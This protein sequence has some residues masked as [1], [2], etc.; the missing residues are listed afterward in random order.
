M[1]VRQIMAI[2]KLLFLGHPLATRQLHQT[3]LPKVLALP[4][5]SSD[6]LSSIAYATQEI[7]LVLGAAGVAALSLLLP[8][9]LSV[10][11]LF[12]IVVLSYRQ[13]VHA[14]PTGGGAYRVAHENLGIY[15]GLLAAAALLVDYILT[16]SVSV[17]AGTDAIA[18]AIPAVQSFSL[19]LTLTFLL[20]VTLVNLRGARQSALLFAIPAYGF[21]AS[22][23]ALIL[24]GLISC[25]HVCPQAPS[26]G[27]HP[28]G[29]VSLSLF[30]ILRAFAGGTTALT[31][32]EAIS[33]GV[34]AF[35][36]PRAGTRRPRLR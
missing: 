16:V 18:A 11:G 19:P 1:T 4:V 15:P 17:T 2:V 23:Y 5:F 25:L 12:V 35:R 7:L 27:L 14:Y 20:L 34:P 29:T 10:A 22:I 28:A 21:V 32:V 3:F 33:N 26:A 24:T 6:A 13:T 30:L 9:S 36:P 8:I 31:G